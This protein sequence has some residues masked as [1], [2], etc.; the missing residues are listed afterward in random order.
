MN[1]RDLSVTGWLWPDKK[2]SALQ[3][4]FCLSGISRRKQG[5]GVVGKDSFL[6]K[7]EHISGHEGGKIVG[8]RII[9]KGALRV[10]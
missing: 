6:W 1:E 4:P 7:P 5:C 9:E 8:K 2:E 10:R 3:V